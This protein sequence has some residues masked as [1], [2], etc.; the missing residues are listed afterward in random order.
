MLLFKEDL[1]I[2]KSKENWQSDEYTILMHIG[3][4]FLMKTQLILMCCVYMSFKEHV[5][6]SSARQVFGSLAFFVVCICVLA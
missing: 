4:Y 6:A 2:L 5:K 1:I 3:T